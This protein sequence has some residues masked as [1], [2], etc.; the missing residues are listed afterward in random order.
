MFVK[1]RGFHAQLWSGQRR[2]WCGISPTKAQEQTNFTEYEVRHLLTLFINPKEKH[3]KYPDGLMTCVPLI[4]EPLDALLLSRRT[5]EI[6][7]HS[8]PRAH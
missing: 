5:C 2:K 6:G 7:A 1:H 8:S 3:A 4:H